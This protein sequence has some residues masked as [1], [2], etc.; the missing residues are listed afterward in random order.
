MMKHEPWQSAAPQFNTYKELIEQYQKQ[1]PKELLELQPRLSSAFQRFIHS[2]HRLMLV[3]MPDSLIYRGFIKNYMA[4]QT[5]SSMP[6]ISS[7]SIQHIDYINKY[8]IINDT[9]HTIEGIFEQSDHGILII[10]ANFIIANANEWP[11]LKS[12]IYGE[13]CEAKSIDPKIIQPKPLAKSYQIKVIITGDREQLAYL[14]EIDDMLRPP[15]CIFGELELEYRV[16]SNTF[17]NYLAYIKSQMIKSQFEDLLDQ[18]SILRYLQQAVRITED[19]EYLPLSPIWHQDLLQE[20]H[21]VQKKSKISQSI[22]AED[23]INAIEYQNYRHS[24]L[25][26]RALEDI[27]EGQVIIETQGERIGQVNG[28]TVVEVSGHPTS[29]GEPARISCV[30]HSGDG[31]ISDVE[32]KTELGGNLHAKGMMIMQAFLSSALELEEPLPF[33]AS[34]VFE[35]SYS[36]VDGDSASLAELTALVSALSN[37]PVNQSIAVTGAVDQFGR[38]QAVGGLNQKIEGFFNICKK[39]GLTGKQGV[40]LPKANLRHLSLMPDIVTAIKDEQ[41]HLWSVESVDDAIPLLLNLAFRHN[42]TDL[43]IDENKDSI[44]NRI[45]QRIHQ[46]HKDEKINENW[47]YRL[48]NKLFVTD[49]TC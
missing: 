9:I 46:L 20:I 12:I 7:E 14:E 43:N 10:S 3:N 47:L 29:Y 26:N 6:I 11:Y 5:K 22:T 21:Y 44:L 33:A 28:L 40:I 19:Q 18:D 8:Q 34:I 23:V 31:D 1:E 38:V 25:P 42:E 49:R 16:D 36:E 24:Y 13:P 39:Q 17:S 4:E 2:S 27:Y 15:H 37:S 32:H 48:K 35:Q 45:D 30:V 41:F